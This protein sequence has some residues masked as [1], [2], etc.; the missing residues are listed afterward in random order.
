MTAQ[1]C[2]ILCTSKVAMLLLNDSTDD[3]TMIHQ[4]YING[5]VIFYNG[6]LCCSLCTQN[7]SVFYSI[8]WTRKW[9]PEVITPPSGDWTA[10]HITTA[11][12]FDISLL[13]SPT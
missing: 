2:V 8:F 4:F 11:E 6:N 1:S 13:N 12:R 3:L 10:L 9:I 7:I 5:I